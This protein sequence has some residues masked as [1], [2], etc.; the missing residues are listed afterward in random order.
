MVKDLLAYV[1]LPDEKAEELLSYVRRQDRREWIVRL[2][3]AVVALVAFVAAALAL[4]LAKQTRLLPSIIA[5]TG[6]ILFFCATFAC[7]LRWVTWGGWTDAG[8]IGPRLP[9]VQRDLERIEGSSLPVELLHLCELAP[10]IK[11]VLRSW[12]VQRMRSIDFRVLKQ[13]AKRI[14]GLE[15]E[16]E[17]NEFLE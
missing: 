4:H 16:I 8:D 13:V 11:P 2:L 10:Q 5:D 7:F 15:A 14:Y 12:G 3:N 6:T 17:L 1:P 9:D